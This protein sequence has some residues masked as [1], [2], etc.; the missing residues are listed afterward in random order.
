MIAHMHEAQTATPLSVTQLTARIKQMLEQG[1]AHVEVTGEVSRL[2]RPASGH[3]YFT[4]KD[5]H[6]AISAVV[7]RSAALR[8]KTLPKEGE[9]FIFSGHLSLYEPRGSY[10]LVVTKIEP[11][12]AG[13]LAA[14]F[15]RRKQV[16]AERGWFDSDHKLT[17]PPLPEHI[18]IVTSPT[19][20]AFEDVKKV[21]S[22]R[23]SWLHLTLSPALVQGNLAPASITKAL[24]Q[25]S[26]MESPP[27][28]ILLVRGGGSI[29]DLWCFN[30]EAVVQAVVDCPI[31][32]IS[33]VGHEIDTTLTDFAADLRA[34]TPSNAAEVCC[35]SREGLRERL[36][37]LATLAGLLGQC[38]NRLSRDL[39]SISQRQ[40][41]LWQRCSDARFHTAEQARTRL[42]HTAHISISRLRTPLRTIEKRLAPLQPGERLQ[43]QRSD[44]SNRDIIL[45]QS[46]RNALQ[47]QRQSLQRTSQALQGEQHQIELKRHRFELLSSKMQELDPTGV[48]K[49]G[50]SMNYRPD[51]EL[52]TSVT[53]LAVGDGVQIHF[54]DGIAETEIKSTQRSGE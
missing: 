35:P 27:D 32:I 19:A 9:E 52:I 36:P 45:N 48:L 20:A 1:F 46:L 44:W 3:L 15:E 12:G 17:L 13:R 40:T 4:I 16:Y 37:K 10:Q 47:L 50:Y 18:G 7:W 53:G 33:G 51:G 26:A 6:A 5:A 11:A 23:P 43:Q 54:H 38:L 34:A 22:T 21:L 28:L 29:E 42:A 25:L 14:E 39:E 30:D 2:T 24:E 31:P 41:S 49:R 8:F